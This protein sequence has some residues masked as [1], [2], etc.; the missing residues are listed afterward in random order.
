LKV[1]HNQLTALPAAI[2]L[3]DLEELD[4]SNNQLRT[5]PAE[6]AQAK[7][8]KFADFRHNQLHD[9]PNEMLGMDWLEWVGLSG[10]AIGGDRI[11]QL[12]EA[13]IFL[14]IDY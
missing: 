3:M 12:H 14:I 11:T 4:V 2:R 5:I 8:L 13:Q 10:N 9:Y 1:D 7:G 6:I